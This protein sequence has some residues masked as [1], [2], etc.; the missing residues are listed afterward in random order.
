MSERMQEEV[1][2]EMLMALADG[3]LEDADAMA[4]RDRIAWDGSLAAR[5]AVFVDTREA[6]HAAFVQGPVP[7]RLVAAV[8][9][10]SADKDDTAKRV[11][12]IRPRRLVDAV[13]PLALAASLV[14]GVG[15]GWG[16]R[17]APSAAPGLQLVAEALSGVPT[18]EASHIEGVGMAR[19][20]GTFE[21][22]R[23]LCR[24]IAAEAGQASQTQFVACHTLDGWQ[25]AMSIS[26][27][28]SEAYHAASGVGTEMIDLFLDSLGAG[29]ALEPDAEAEALR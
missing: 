26:E 2:D 4:L 1:S 22:E 19:V 5:Y 14:I 12:E 23:G 7:G 24:L 3:E 21:T 28:S 15:I 10:A 9:A 16:L 20:L 18:G 25:V 11:V 29:A 8:H 6:L 17:D 13:W 27:G